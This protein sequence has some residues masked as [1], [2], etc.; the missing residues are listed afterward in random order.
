MP[1]RLQGQLR[2]DQRRKAFVANHAKAIV[3]CDFLT[4][5]T[6]TFKCLY[7]FVI[8]IRN[9]KAVTPLVDYSA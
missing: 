6:M 7:V 2:G 1:K 3:A 4:E 8:I 5:V 9:T